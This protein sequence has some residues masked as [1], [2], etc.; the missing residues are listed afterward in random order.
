MNVPVL[1][2]KYHEN[3]L[4]FFTGHTEVLLVR[5]EC[6]RCPL[7]LAKTKV[8]TILDI[9][10]LFSSSYRRYSKPQKGSSYGF[11]FF[12]E[13]LK[14]YNKNSGKKIKFGPLPLGPL[15]GDFRFF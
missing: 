3:R 6:V 11:K 5:A 4:T 8:A 1:S 9:F 14:K 15:G 2:K 13:L 7:L 12:H 10:F